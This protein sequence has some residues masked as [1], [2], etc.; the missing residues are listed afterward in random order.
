MVE[1]SSLLLIEP[2]SITLISYPRKNMI[3]NMIA[4]D[5]KTKIAKI[6]KKIKNARVN[7]EKNSK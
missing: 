6:P 3:N 4:L 1:V 2:V 5:A 7:L